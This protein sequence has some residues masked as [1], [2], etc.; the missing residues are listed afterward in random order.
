[1]VRDFY[2]KYTVDEHTLLTI[3]NL[4]RLAS[5]CPPGE[6]L[7]S[8]IHDLDRPELLVLSLLFHDVGKWKDKDHA[9]ESVR[10]ADHM[11]TRLHMPLEAREVV[12][13][14]IKNHLQMSRVA[15]HRDTEDPEIVKEFAALVGI[16]ERLRLL[17]LMTIADVGAVSPETLTP[18]K[19]ELLWRLY[20]DTYNHLTHAY[21]DE[22]ID[23]RQARRSGLLSGRPA[24]MPEAEITEFLEGLPR[25]YLQ[26]ASREIIYAHVRL[27][28]NIS[29]DE[30]H[31][32]LERRESVW[33]LTVVTLDKPY[34]FSNI[35]GV[36]VLVRHGH[37]PGPCDDDVQGPRARHRAVCGSGAVSRAESR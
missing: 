26:L 6:R 28:R 29:G 27:S 2:H 14:L 12:D 7:A 33:E 19:E 11:M 1:M 20:V 37:P 9:T 18:W 30:V 22:L 16:E 5:A 3:R 23:R 4:E 36:P 34:L 15:F 17:C 25:R 21:A 10:M 8:L 13:F 31:V 24:D 32:K 35:C